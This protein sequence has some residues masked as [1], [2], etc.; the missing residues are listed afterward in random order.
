MKVTRLWFADERIYIE[1]DKGETLYQLLKFYPRLL[2]A[3][4]EERNS[5]ELEPFG[6]HWENIDEDVSYESF[7]F[8]ETKEVKCDVQELFLSHPELN[9]SAI[10]RKMGIQQSLLA[11]YIN[12][13]KKP[14]EERKKLI[15]ET[16]HTIGNEL[17]EIRF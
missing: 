14:S 17:L 13:T 16:V 1:N 5:Y 7:Y 10:A 9:I 12:G 4:N 15:L 8:E 3:T 11:S 2:L 6:I